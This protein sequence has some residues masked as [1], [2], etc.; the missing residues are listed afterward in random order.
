M[1]PT[2]ADSKFSAPNWRDHFAEWNHTNFEIRGQATA[3]EVLAATDARDVISPTE[4]L[5]ALTD[6]VPSV[7]PRLAATVQ[8]CVK[9]ACEVEV[10]PEPATVDTKPAA[11]VFT[12]LTQQAVR[13]AECPFAKRDEEMTPNNGR[14]SGKTNSEGVA[15]TWNNGEVRAKRL[16]REGVQV[17]LPSREVR[18]YTCVREAF[19]SL[20]LDVKKHIKFRVR[21]K[22]KRELAFEADSGASYLFKIVQRA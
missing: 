8:T 22:A 2:V 17:T 10:D 18:L 11:S 9:P 16:V 20:R 15:R 7:R 13:V 12:A 14:L 1:F 21:L 19:E 5:R 6:A 3:S 4:R